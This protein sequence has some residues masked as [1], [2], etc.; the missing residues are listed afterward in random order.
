[1]S[2]DVNKGKYLRLKIRLL[3]QK[4]EREEK[5]KGSSRGF[6]NSRIAEVTK[7]QLFINFNRISGEIDSSF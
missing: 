4:S 5:S 1:M 3:L 7:F 6:W 2:S